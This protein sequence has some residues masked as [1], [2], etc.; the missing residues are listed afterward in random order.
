M[1]DADVEDRD[2]IFPLYVGYKCKYDQLFGGVVKI[3]KEKKKKKKKTVSKMETL[4]WYTEALTAR[5]S[6]IPFF[7]IFLVFLFLLVLFINFFYV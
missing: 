4:D 7:F 6:L 3:R 5:K 1:Q 2:G